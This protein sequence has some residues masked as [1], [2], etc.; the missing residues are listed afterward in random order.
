MYRI[1]RTREKEERSGQKH[2]RSQIEK[3]ILPEGGQWR[4]PTH[5]TTGSG[6]C[7]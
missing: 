6:N 3:N 5:G 4:E 7:R 1:Y 2:K